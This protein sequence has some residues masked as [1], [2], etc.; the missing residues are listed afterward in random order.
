MELQSQSAEDA[1]HIHIVRSTLSKLCVCIPAVCDPSVFTGACGSHL[2]IM[3]V[4]ETL[5]CVCECECSEI[6][7]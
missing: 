6:V 2:Y 5:L 1:S 4:F 3:C 7:M